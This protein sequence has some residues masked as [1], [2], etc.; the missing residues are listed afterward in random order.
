MLNENAR[1]AQSRA[2]LA[3]ATRRLLMAWGDLHTSVSC[4]ARSMA[5]VAVT[6]NQ[7]HGVSSKARVTLLPDSG[8]CTYTRIQ[9]SGA[10]CVCEITVVWSSRE[11]T[12]GPLFAWKPP[13]TPKIKYK[14]VGRTKLTFY[15]SRRPPAL[16][17][18]YLIG[19]L[20]PNVNKPA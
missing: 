4:S 10:I 12:F 16:I 11:K 17:N 1:S 18:K 8:V 9:Q 3:F 15:L 2:T 6:S 20:P 13:E 19:H 5:V 14:V 7:S